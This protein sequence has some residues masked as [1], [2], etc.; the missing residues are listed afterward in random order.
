M[1][2]FASAFFSIA[3]LVNVAL[4]IAVVGILGVGMTAVILTGGIDLS[5]GSVVALVGVVCAMVGHLGGESF[6]GVAGAVA[7]GLTVGA[8]L[9]AVIGWLVA[10][11]RVPAFL[12]TLA[13]F[14]IARGLG[15]VLSGG[16]SIGDLPSGLSWL[17]QGLALGI[18]VPVLVMGLVLVV[19]WFVLTRTTWGR[20]VYATGGNEQAAWLAGINTR[21]VTFWTYVANGLLVALAGITLAARLGAGVPNA[22][23]GYELDVIAAVVVGGTSLVGGR[24]GV[25]GTLIGA[26]F[27]GVLNNALNLADVDP[28][29]QRIVLG[30][31]IL[32]AV[33]AGRVRLAIGLGSSERSP[34]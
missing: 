30:L 18:P 20:W 14:S 21:A 26:V 17:G 2:S 3:N 16:R 15:F 7:S 25:M 28:Y 23:L 13:L 33:V 8:T 6:L 24:G 22:G 29:M 31:V 11:W 5:V 9:G 10:W 4:S 32:V 12:V 34:S 1:F 19:G 27:I